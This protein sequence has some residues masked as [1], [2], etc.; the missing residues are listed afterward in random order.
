MRVPV[1]TSYSRRLETHPRWSLP[2]SRFVVAVG[3]VLSWV[4]LLGTATLLWR[5]VYLAFTLLVELP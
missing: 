4:A 3:T 2:S 1:V 5:G